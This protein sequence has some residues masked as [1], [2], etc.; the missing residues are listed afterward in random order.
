MVQYIF[1]KLLKDSAACRSDVAEVSTPTFQNDIGRF[2]GELWVPNRGLFE[3]VV[4]VGLIVTFVEADFVG[5]A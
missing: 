5:S 2:I 1:E 4:D 3:A